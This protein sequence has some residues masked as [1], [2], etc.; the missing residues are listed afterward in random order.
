MQ[1]EAHEI[2]CREL[3]GGGRTRTEQ[4]KSRKGG[5]M[6][7]TDPIPLE[8]S[9]NLSMDINKHWIRPNRD[10]PLLEFPFQ[11]LFLKRELLLI[12]SSVKISLNY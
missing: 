3:S 4:R 11:L 8:F 12:L 2:Q 1:E 9:E 7:V 6:Y 5:N 10:W